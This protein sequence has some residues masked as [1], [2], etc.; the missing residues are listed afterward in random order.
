MQIRV[1]PDPRFEREGN[2]VRSSIE[3]SVTDAILGAEIEAE[4]VRG[5]VTLKIPEGTQ[6]GQVLRIKAKGLPELGSS[7]SG[8]HYVT[9]M[10]KIPTKLSRTER[11]LLEEWRGV[12]E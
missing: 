4:T 8:D 12:R 2:D 9:V 7:R 1:P 6:P 3:I 11:K 5:T 10:V